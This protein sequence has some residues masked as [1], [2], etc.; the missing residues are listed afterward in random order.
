[1]NLRGFVRKLTLTGLALS[2]ALLGGRTL[3]DETIKGQVLGAGA[4]IAKST[5]TLWA[6]SADTPKQIAQTRTGDDGRF[7]VHSVET[8]RATLKGKRSGAVSSTS[9][10]AEPILYLVAAGGE[11]KVSKIS[12]DNPAIVLLTVVGSN[13]PTSV[14]VNEFTTVASVWTHAQFLNGSAIQGPPLGLRIAAGNVPN[15]VDIETGGYGGAILGPLNSTQT[16]TMANFATISTLL[17][18]CIARVKLDAC[19]RDRKST[20]LNSSHEFVSRMPSSA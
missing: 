13:P 9:A 18:G 3:A 8:G 4:P 15:F 5:V 17:A 11:S 6:A 7:V 16:P 20:R 14:V 2:S 19:S 10:S 12:G 1:M